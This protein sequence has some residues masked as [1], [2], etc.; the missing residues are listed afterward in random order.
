MS[1]R[2]TCARTGTR[3]Q[4]IPI[5]G[6]IH[7]ENGSHFSDVSIRMAKNWNNIKARGFRMQPASVSFDLL[8][9]SAEGETYPH[10]HSRQAL[11]ENVIIAW[12]NFNKC[13]HAMYPMNCYA[14]VFAFYTHTHTHK[15]RA[16]PNEEKN[17]GRLWLI[18]LDQSWNELFSVFTSKCSRGVCW[19]VREYVCFQ[20]NE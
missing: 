11:D 14:D 4:E 20:R 1:M 3:K 10:T 15:Q 18:T 8:I 17:E 2:L 6:H 5:S 19:C 7:Q 16:K 13:M 9:K 12:N